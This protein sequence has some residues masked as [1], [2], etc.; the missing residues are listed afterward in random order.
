MQRE[1]T[2]LVRN[3]EVAL[4]I[5][6]CAL[7]ALPVAVLPARRI[8]APCGI[9]AAICDLEA[10]N[11]APDRAREIGIGRGDD[12]LALLARL[13]PPPRHA[14]LI[15]AGER[16]VGGRAR[17]ILDPHVAHDPR[18]R[19]GVR[20][21]AQREIVVGEHMRPRD[22]AVLGCPVGIDVARGHVLHPEGLNGWRD[23]FGAEGR[24]PQPAHVI[25]L[26]FGEVCR[27]GHD[28]LEEGHPRLEDADIV[29]L[30]HRGKAARVGED[31]R[32]FAYQRGHPRHQRRADQIALAG[33]P[34]RIGNHEQGVAGLRVEA[35]LHRLGDARGIA[36]R[37]DDPLGLAGAARGVDEE[38]RIVGID[39]QRLRG[40]PDRADEIGSGERQ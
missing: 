10:R 38:H 33:D 39:R 6:P 1:R 27:I 26:D 29:P 31:G 11:V 40:S 9:D 17:L 32:A 12:D 18:Q 19:I 30:D 14:A 7:P 37:V 34:A 35:H 8:A 22:P 20:I 2:V 4:G 28:R 21:G 16:N 3:R 24:D 5:G 15:G 25:P 23:R 36:V 13:G